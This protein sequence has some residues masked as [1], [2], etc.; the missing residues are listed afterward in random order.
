MDRRTCKLEIYLFTLGKK[1]ISATGKNIKL[2]SYRTSR[3]FCM[4]Y[5]IK[6]DVHSNMARPFL[7]HN[8]NNNNTIISFSYGDSGDKN[9]NTVIKNVLEG[10][11]SIEGLNALLISLRICA[12]CCTFSANKVI[13]SYYYKDTFCR[14]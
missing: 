12:Y 8:N 1:F 2:H 3:L 10:G 5:Y 4:K 7:C 6:Y 13:I 11:C 9:A 14:F